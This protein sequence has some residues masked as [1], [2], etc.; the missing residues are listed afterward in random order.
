ML[1]DSQIF[2][3]VYY[4]INLPLCKYQYC[5]RTTSHLTTFADHQKEID[6]KPQP[7]PSFICTQVSFLSYYS[8]VICRTNYLEICHKEENSLIPSIF[9]TFSKSA[10]RETGSGAYP[11]CHGVRG[12]VQLDRPPVYHGDIETDN[13]SHTVQLIYG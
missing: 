8:C 7:G 5:H 12:V 13:H 2:I 6:F 3:K 1:F 9:L 11:S 10:L 4:C